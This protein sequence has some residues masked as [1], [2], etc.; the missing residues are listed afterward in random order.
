MIQV[1][2]RSIANLESL[3]GDSF[4]RAV[5]EILACRGMVV[6]TGMGK[7]G[8]I[9]AKIS[10]TFASTGTPS[11][12]LHPGEALHGDLGRIRAE[13]VLLALS[14]S[15]ETAE[16][17][18]LCSPIKKIGARLVAMTGKQDSSLAKLADCVLDI[19]SVDEACPLGLAPTASTSAMLALGDALAMCVQSER[20]FSREDYARFH[21]AGD[22]GRR[23]MRVDEIMRRDD[24]LPVVPSGAKVTEVLMTMSSTAGRPGAALVVDGDGRLAGI[25]TDGD[26]RRILG[27]GDP[28]SL[29]HPVVEFMGRDPK[30]VRPDQLV[31]EAERVLREFQID[32]VAVVT[33]DQR[34][35]G[36]LDIQDILQVRL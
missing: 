35:V 11:L 24:A 12:S 3:L 13:D 22:L 30:C 32:Q 25:F 34:P 6:V 23:L 8:L 7:A 33:D 18:A 5:D 26:L 17:K 16:L 10:A 14:N 4:D 1:E 29:Q 27:G 36:L 31:E 15:G 9:G 21:P 19:G 28:E 20:G 2:A